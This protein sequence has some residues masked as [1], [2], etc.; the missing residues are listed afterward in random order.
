[1]LVVE[2]IVDSGLTLQYL[3]DVLRRRN[4]ADLRVVALLKKEKAGRDRR[5]RSIWSGS[6]SRTN[7]SSATDS[8][9]PESTATCHMWPSSTRQLIQRRLTAGAILRTRAA[10]ASTSRV[11]GR[12]RDDGRH[13]WATSNWLRNGF[14][15]II[16]IV[17]VIALWFTLVGRDGP[18]RELQLG[19]LVAATSTPAR[20]TKLIQDE[21]QPGRSRSTTTKDGR[22]VQGES[23]SPAKTGILE[24][25]KQLQ[26]RSFDLATD[27]DRHQAGQPVGRLARRARASCC[28]RCS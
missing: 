3:L 13:R 4:P 1:M 21:G 23:S 27:S 9:T 17:A 12:P 26:R 28:R 24:M 14:V 10:Q 6:P 5:S 25:L 22:P 19:E 8:T 20:S 16:L 2:D 7:S 11:A 15:W 18:R